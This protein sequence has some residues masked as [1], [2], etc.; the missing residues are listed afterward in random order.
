MD[1]PTQA[2]DILMMMVGSS[3]LMGLA[4]G[5]GS[6]VLTSFQRR[7]QANVDPKGWQAEPFDV[8]REAVLRRESF[9]FRNFESLVVEWARWIDL[10]PP[11]V[12]SKLD[13]ALAVRAEKAPWESSEYLAVSRL[14]SFGPFLV[15]TFFVA[16]VGM[17]GGVSLAVS[18]G[19]GVVFGVLAAAGYRALL[20]QEVVTRAERKRWAI[21]S[22]LPYAVDLIALMLEAGATFNEAVGNVVDEMR[23]HPLGI[24]LN[25]VLSEMNLGRPR[26]EALQEL[27]DRLNDD[28]LSE[29]IFSVIKG[30]EL[31]TPLV[32]I[33]S[34]LADQMRLKR[35]QWVEKAAAEA[36]VQIV[37]PGMVTMIAC[38]LI[39]ITPFILAAF[40]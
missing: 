14:A 22:R 9:V 26:R 35:S 2:S 10:S 4:V 33:F 11:A 21:K 27:A 23:D 16:A 13:R 17:I 8:S 6:L 37:F 7:K 30:E 18:G 34:T 29:V 38:L 36:Q 5:L 39:I 3:V 15:A 24:E 32:N 12:I 25:Q 31:G 28:D 20:I 19:A 1:E 40:F